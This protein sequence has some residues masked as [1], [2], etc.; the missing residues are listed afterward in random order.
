MLKMAMLKVQMAKAQMSKNLPQMQ[1]PLLLQGRR[2]NRIL[3]RKNPVRLYLTVPDLAQ[4]PMRKLMMSNIYRNV[5]IFLFPPIV[6]DG[7]MR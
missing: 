5:S 6:N 4:Q 2:A 7:K 3:L 1:I